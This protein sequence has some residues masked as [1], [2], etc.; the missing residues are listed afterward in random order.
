MIMVMRA[1]IA[2]IS[3]YI[4][5]WVSLNPY[6]SRIIGIPRCSLIITIIARAECYH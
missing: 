2:R 3:F 5:S 6:W 4:R 1:M